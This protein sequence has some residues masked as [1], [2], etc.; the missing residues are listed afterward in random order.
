M[1]NFKSFENFSKLI[2]IISKKRKLQLVLL[3]FASIF[4]AIIEILNISLI[5]PYLDFVG[6]GNL[7]NQF[8]F[9]FLNIGL[10]SQENYLINISFLLLGSILLSMLFRIFTLFS[11]Y[12]ISSSIASDLG[13]KIFKRSLNMP[14]SWHLKNNTSILKGYLTKD[15]DNVSEYVNGMTKFLVNS[16]ISFSIGL[17]LVL[18]YPKRTS[19]L[20]IVLF[21][22]FFIIFIF[23]K[24]SLNSDGNSYSRK[25]Q[26]TI[27]I[28]DESLLNIELIKIFN[29][30]DFH[31]KKFKI[32]NRQFRHMGAKINIKAQ[33]PR[34][35]IESFLLIIIVTTALIISFNSKTL[36]NEIAFIGTVGL[37]IYKI[38][39]PMQQMFNGISAME[40]YKPSFEKISNFLLF[41]QKNIK[42]KRR[43]EIHENHYYLNISNIYFKY[44]SKEKYTLKK[45]NLKVKKGE[46]IGLVGFSGSGKSTFIKLLL[47]L[48]A[49]SKGYIINY[50]KNIFESR[51]NLREWQN[52]ISYVS[53]DV[54]FSDDDLRANIGF[55]LEKDN[56][57]DKKIVSSSKISE[58]DNYIQT[59]PKKY[60]NLIGEKGFKFSG[61]QRQRIAIA[62]ALYRD[63]NF[64]ILDEA[65]SS[66]DSQNEYKIINNLFNNFQ[67]NTIFLIS[68]KLLSLKRCDKIILLNNGIIEDVG[69]FSDL[70]KENDLFKKML[71]SEKYI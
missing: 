64:L 11:Q 25:Y 32:P 21:F 55:G 15:V 43:K 70:E 66:L 24:R 16:I 45:I 41:N 63:H 37:G 52:K 42:L 5:F 22:I 65:L 1:L 36:Q 3:L 69:T 33:S 4:S 60:L 46:K 31:N 68:H 58:I 48:L 40:A 50:G 71:N 38:L 59:L 62:R 17:Y 9:K 44:D 23:L 53:Q 34:L 29:K 6:T 12:I 67:E 10:I 47:G 35:I 18:L 19:I 54:F 57:N 7:S 2:K 49:P 13:L 14:Y 26:E 61:G 56:I 8:S 27:K 28:I 20:I 39:T 51:E 30:F